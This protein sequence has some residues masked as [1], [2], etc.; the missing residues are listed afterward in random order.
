MC[1]GSR[2]GDGDAARSREFDRMIRQD[3]KRMAKEVKLLL[4]GKE[5]ASLPSLP[6][7]PRSGQAHACP[8]GRGPLHLARGGIRVHVSSVADAHLVR[9]NQALES[10]ASRRCSSR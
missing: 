8:C 9:P 5:S 7:P 4:L 2:K 3:E 6:K 10:Q 1:F